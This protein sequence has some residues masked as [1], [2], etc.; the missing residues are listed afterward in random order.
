MEVDSL[1]FMNDFDALSQRLSQ[2]SR[3]HMYYMTAVQ[4]HTL[5][6]TTI[7]SCNSTGS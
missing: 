2:R 4:Y 5:Y 1:R 7:S 3:V 6:L